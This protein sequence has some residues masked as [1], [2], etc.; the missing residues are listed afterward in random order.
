MMHQSNYLDKTSGSDRPFLVVS[1]VVI[2]YVHRLFARLYACLSAANYSVPGA[3][4]GSCAC[5]SPHFS[6]P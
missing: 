3:Y 6:R 5:P 1:A 4:R 2:L